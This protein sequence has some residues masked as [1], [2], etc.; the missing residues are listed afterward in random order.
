MGPTDSKF[1]Q[2]LKLGQQQDTQFFYNE[3]G[4]RFKRVFSV[5]GKSPFD[6]VEYEKRTSIIREPDGKVVFEMKDIEIPKQWSQVAT[7]IIAQ[8]YFRKTGVPQLNADGTQKKNADGSPML[9]PETSAKQTIHRLAG[10][11]RYW[12]EQIGRAHV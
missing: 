5:E 12:G 3:N 2:G 9:G 1:I 4:L 6:L 8:K 10:T 11:W 7:D